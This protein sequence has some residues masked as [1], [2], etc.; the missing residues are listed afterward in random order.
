MTTV[1]TEQIQSNF[2][3][4]RELIT[5]GETL[6][7]EENGI[8]LGTII[9]AGIAES[10]NRSKRVFGGLEGKIKVPADFDEMMRDEIEEMFYGK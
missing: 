8:P 5:G 1:T 7:L 3:S 10:S 9:P 6:L 2:A 4:V